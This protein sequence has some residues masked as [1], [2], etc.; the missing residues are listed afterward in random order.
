MHLTWDFTPIHPP[1]LHFCRWLLT[2]AGDR[3]WQ[4]CGLLAD[5]AA[6]CIAGP[7]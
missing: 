2:T 3:R 1:D 5:W 7:L 6:D 4:F